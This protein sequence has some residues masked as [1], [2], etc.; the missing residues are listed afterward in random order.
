MTKKILSLAL[1]LCMLLSFNA[2]A[3]FSAFAADENSGSCGVNATYTYDEDTATITVSGKGLIKASSFEFNKEVE[4]LVINE[5]ITGIGREAF[6]SCDRLFDISLPS[7]LLYIGESA[8]S[9]CDSLGK[10]EIPE[11]V[12]RIY[13]FAFENCENLNDVSFPSTLTSIGECAFAYDYGFT[14][15]AVPDTV[16]T[17]GDSAFGDVNN[18]EYS[19]TLSTTDWGAK[20]VN[21]CVD[22]Y[23]VYTDSTKSKLTGCSALATAVEVPATVQEIGNYAFR[24]C[25]KL[26]DLTLAEGLVTIDEGAFENCTELYDV[27][28]P[29]TLKT[30]GQYAFSVCESL[31]DIVIPENVT[32]VGEGAFSSCEYLNSVKLPDG[33]TAVK[34]S[35]FSACERLQKVNIPSSAKYIGDYAFA[36]CASLPSIEIPEGVTSIRSYAFES[37]QALNN[38]VLPSTVK[39]IGDCA[40]ENCSS[41]KSITIPASVGKIGADAFADC[42]KN[43]VIK[44]TCN[45]YAAQ[46]ANTN[47]IKASLTGCKNKSVTTKATTTKN[48]KIEK[49]CTVCGN[50]VS[51]TVIPKASSIKLSSVSY[52]YDGKAKTPTVTVKDSKGNTLVKN[53]DYTVSYASG[54]KNVGK[55][56]VKI[57]FKGKYSGTKTLN[58]KILPKST[59]ITKLTATKGGFNVSWKKQATQTTGYDIQYSTSSNFSNAKTLCVANKSTTSRKLTCLSKGKKYYVRVRT[60]KTV[61]GTKYASK[62]SSVKTVTTKK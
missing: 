61:N 3:D 18:V 12:K 28:F 35:L 39:V 55:Y 59:S 60:Y 4:R 53:T 52:T 21:G 30:I 46:Y 31:T 40:F 14:S 34:P 20:T 2:A 49:K 22:G 1:S 8:F 57:T 11:G 36:Y 54:R 23:L 43:L 32:E 5:G 15:I 24:F 16:K 25:N 41:L 58:F 13:D 47:K 17:V 50:V 9:W 56:T 48:G 26:T 51:S 19:G 37:A 29:K 44:S 45:S 6:Y 7:T 10:V 38:V 42:N 33:L 62:W 27:T